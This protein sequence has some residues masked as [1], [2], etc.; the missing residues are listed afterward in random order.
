VCDLDFDDIK[1]LY[2][3]CKYNEGGLKKNFNQELETN[4]DDRAIKFHHLSLE[5]VIQLEKNTQIFSS[6]KELKILEDFKKNK[7]LIAG[8][9][10]LGLAVHN[11]DIDVI[12]AS[13]DLDQ[14]K[15]ELTSQY[16]QFKN[17][18]IKTEFIKNE[19]SLICN[20]NF[21]EI[22]FEI[23]VQRIDSVKQT[24]YRHFLIE[25]R[26]LKLGQ[27][28]LSEKIKVYRKQG[29][30]TEPAFT[31]ALGLHGDAYQILLDLQRKS[32][33]ELKLLLSGLN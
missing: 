18:R 2:P 20:F 27:N 29:L 25:E 17:F 26:L 33:S 22:A 1:K 9:F 31:K 7:P 16:S 15:L 32:E 12:M 23:F 6:L 3:N 5:S 10:P 8:T 4:L 11:S 19:L 21:Q 28:L 30:K 13:V 24:A 14:I